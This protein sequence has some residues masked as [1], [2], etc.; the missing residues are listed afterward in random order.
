MKVLVA[1][2]VARE[3]IELL[4][5]HHEVDERLGCTPAEL[6]ELT[7]GGLAVA[8]VGGVLLLAGVGLGLASLGWLLAGR[9]AVPVL[10]TGVVKYGGFGVAGLADVLGITALVLVGVGV[11]IAAIP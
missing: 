11:V 4:A 5:A 8:G 10:T 2:S 9:F 1:E 7:L 3:G 6:A